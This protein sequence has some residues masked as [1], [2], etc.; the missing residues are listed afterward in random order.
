VSEG[1]ELSFTHWIRKLWRN[2]AAKKPCRT[3]HS[4]TLAPVAIPR[5]QLRTAGIAST[6]RRNE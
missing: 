5:D 4:A 2:S 3:N 6:R 1:A